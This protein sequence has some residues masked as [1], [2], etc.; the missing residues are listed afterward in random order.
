MSVCPSKLEWKPLI[1]AVLIGPCWIW[2]TIKPTVGFLRTSL[3]TMQPVMKLL[4]RRYFNV[5]NDERS[6]TNANAT[7]GGTGPK[8][9]GKSSVTRSQNRTLKLNPRSDTTFRRLDN[10]ESGE[11]PVLWRAGYGL[12]TGSQGHRQPKGSPMG[13]HASLLDSLLLRHQA[14]AQEELSERL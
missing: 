13:S 2:T 10:D 1:F 6:E 4:F 12:Q 8:K 5:S 9:S 14:S 7:I 3:P 11:E